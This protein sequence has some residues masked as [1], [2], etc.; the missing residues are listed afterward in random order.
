M[1]VIFKLSFEE[2]SQ[3]IQKK[4]KKTDYTLSFVITD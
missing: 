4:H 1:M 2:I 3:K